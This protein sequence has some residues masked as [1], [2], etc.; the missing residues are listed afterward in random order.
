MTLYLILITAAFSIYAFSKASVVDRFDFNPTRILQ[1]REVYRLLTNGFL[2]ADW[3]HLALN[4]FVLLNFGPLVEAH[5]KSIDQANGGQWY[6]V[7]Y[8]SAIVASILPTLIQQKRNPNYHGLGASGAVSAVLFSSVLFR[9]MDKLCFIFGLCLPGILMGVGYLLYSYYAAR[10]SNDHI[11]H[12][13]HFWGA[14]YGI[15]FSLMLHP[16]IGVDFIRQLQEAGFS[17]FLPGN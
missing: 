6:L 16:N 7:M 10:K 13:A 8:C 11:N 14:L 15:L 9:P 3:L 17:G 1:H 4:M 5:Y 12:D 2:H